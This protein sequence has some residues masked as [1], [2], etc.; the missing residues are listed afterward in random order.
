MK[1]SVMK[2]LE[3]SDPKITEIALKN[4]IL[5]S[6]EARYNHKLHG[7]LLIC[8]G[9][10]SYDVAEV[11]GQN[12][13]TMQRWVKSFEKSGFSALEDGNRTGRPQRLE[14]SQLNKI[15]AVLRKSPR[16]LG[17]EQNLWDGQLLA[18]FI[19][20]T[21]KIDLGSRQCQRLFHQLGFRLRKPRPVI[22]QANPMKKEAFKK[23]L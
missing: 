22:G 10:T 19:K 1:G 8:R 6:K 15:D 18:H 5:Q 20:Q 23:T 7:L 16:D 12:A 9:Y 2:R 3:I 4:E 13:T 14:P 21:F 11:F 17:Y